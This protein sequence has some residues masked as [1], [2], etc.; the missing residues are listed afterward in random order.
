MALRWLQICWE[1]RPWHLSITARLW[2]YVNGTIQTF[3]LIT[4]CKMIDTLF[5]KTST[6][7][8]NIIYLFDLLSYL[9]ISLFQLIIFLFVVVDFLYFAYACL[10]KN[11]TR[12]EYVAASQRYSKLI[13][14]HF[15][16]T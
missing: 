2:S 16:P 1:R 3:Y 11:C 6:N 15:T 8:H 10:R 9:C 13:S 5:L 14:H 7:I 12:S 4:K